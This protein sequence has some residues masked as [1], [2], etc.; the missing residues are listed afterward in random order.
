VNEVSK[1]RA[2]P[3]WLIVLLTALSI[4]AH[5]FLAEARQP[6]AKPGACCAKCQCC[7]ESQPVMPPAPVAPASSR[8]AV[9]KEF[10]AA[11]PVVVAPV[12]PLVIRL[13][14]AAGPEADPTHFPPIF[15]RHLAL[16]I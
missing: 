11:A 1:Y 9:L 16:L 3:K 8:A 13:I 4:V 6:V 12:H 7:I 10:Q 5:P 14:T 15:L 2:M